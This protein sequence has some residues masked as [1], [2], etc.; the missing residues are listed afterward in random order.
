MKSLRNITLSLCI[1][2]IVLLA[3]NL[4]VILPTFKQVQELQSIRSGRFATPKT[5]T[6]E[7]ISIEGKEIEKTI[8]VTGSG[9]ASTKPEIAMI[10]LSVI[11][12]SETA[13]EAQRLNAERMNDVINALKEAGIKDNQITTLGYSLRPILE[14][15]KDLK[16][17]VIIG[18]ECVNTIRVT[19]EELDKVGEIIDLAVSAGANEV[20]SIRFTLKPETMKELKLEALAKAIEDAKAKASTIAEAAGVTL[21]GPITISIGSMYIPRT[22]EF[23]APMKGETPI[24]APEE[25]SVTITVT[26]VYAFD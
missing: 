19:L 6:T 8:S 24:I 2:A 13:S 5:F 16:R 3:I 15:D 20:S 26:V 9:T 12:R 14:Y 23:L 17:T 11:T 7:T 10:T 21:I 22:T 4:V 1:I 18:Y 25:L